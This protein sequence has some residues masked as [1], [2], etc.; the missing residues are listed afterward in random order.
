V[1]FYKKSVLFIRVRCRLDEI[2]QFSCTFVIDDAFF[3]SA[4]ASAVNVEIWIHAELWI[5]SGLVIG[6]VEKM[7]SQKFPKRIQLFYEP[8]V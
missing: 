1:L 4:I 3:R 6:I 2:I 7:Y 8:R 5:F